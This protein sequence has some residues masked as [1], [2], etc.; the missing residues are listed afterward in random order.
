M[1]LSAL[2]EGLFGGAVGG[3]MIVL[4]LSRWLGDV[5]LGRLLEKE[6]A[7][8]AEA[9]EKLKAAIAQELERYRAQ[10]DRSVFVTR[11][12]FETEFTA[13]K[14][15]SQCLSEV[16]VAFRSLHPIDAAVKI[17]DAERTERINWLARANNKYLEKL[18]EWAVFLEPSLYS[19]FEHAYVAA[20]DEWRRLKTNAE[21]PDRAGTVRYFWKSYQQACQLVRD[22]IKS[23]AVMPRT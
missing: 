8:Y 20:N 1:D 17:T 7:K 2:L 15:V 13:M 5:W 19:E 14:E 23:L 11:A 9:I 6:K 4:G 10:L 3:T 18:E 21:E 12:H 16:K 22:R